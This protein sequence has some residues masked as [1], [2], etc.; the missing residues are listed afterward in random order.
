MNQVSLL[1]IQLSTY[2]EDFQ[3]ERKDREAAQDRVI[4]LEQE[5]TDLVRSLYFWSFMVISFK[6]GL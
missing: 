1:E 4:R 6:H 5:L 2:R 3:M